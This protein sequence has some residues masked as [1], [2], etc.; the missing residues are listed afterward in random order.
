MASGEPIAAAGGVLVREL[1]GK[2]QVLLVHRPRYDDWALPKGKLEEGESPEQAAIREV[3][4]ETGYEV[5]LGDALGEISYP[6]KGRPKL[7]YFWRMHP[8]GHSQ[9]IQDHGEV[10]EAV[11]LPL[12]DALTRMSYPLEK[13]VLMRAFGGAAGGAE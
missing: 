3:R 8:R 7:I 5:T 13:Q 9:G 12:E 11:W 4:E 2:V 10:M 6:V 1:E